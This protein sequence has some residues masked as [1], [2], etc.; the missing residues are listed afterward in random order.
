ML[1]KRALVLRDA[2][3]IDRDMLLF[4]PKKASFIKHDISENLVHAQKPIDIVAEL[5]E[6]NPEEWV[7]FRAR[8][9]DAGGSD[10]TGETFYGPNDNGDYFSEEEL[11][12]EAENGEKAF[13]TFIG[14][15]I[16]KIIKTMI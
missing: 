10:L 15:S 16:F 5:K 13:E 6:K 7:F 3:I 14:C 4:G 2:S 11:L 1:I 8:A 12:K 9:I